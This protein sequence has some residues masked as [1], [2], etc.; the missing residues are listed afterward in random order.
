MYTFLPDI[1]YEYGTVEC[2]FLVC[3]GNDHF[4]TKKI[5]ETIFMY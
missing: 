1:E 3:K 5:L 2:T 4:L